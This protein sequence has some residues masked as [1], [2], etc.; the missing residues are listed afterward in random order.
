MLTNPSPRLLPRIPPVYRFAFLG[1]VVGILF[2]VTVVWQPEKVAEA[3][4]DPAEAA[5][6]VPQVDRRLLTE[7]GDATREE[8]LMLEAEPLR[9]L[10]GIAIDVGPSTA[11]ALG[12]PAVP[13][14]VDEVRANMG[15][16][17]GRW[18][19]YEGVLEDLQGPREGHPIA[20]YSI[21]EA[22]IRVAS[23][24]KVLA[25]FSIPPR[26]GIA[27]GSWVKA[28]GFLLKLRDTTYPVD[29]D[30]APM[31]VGREL[32]PDYEDW[33]P[34]TELDETL[35]ATI[36]D[37]DYFPGTK[38]W[39]TLEEDQTEPLWHLAAFVRDTKQQRSLADWRKIEPLNATSKVYE[40]LK[41]N[42]LARGT[43][44]RVFGTLVRRRVLAAP[45]NPAGVTFWT[46]AWVQVREFGG[47]LIP[48]W[49]P[50]RSELPTG[51]PLEVRGFYYR[52]QAYE[53]LKGDRFRVPLFVAADL[54]PYEL[55]ADRTMREIGIGLA[56]VLT[57][58]MGLFWLAQRRA[59]RAS[60]AHSR[61]M[62]ARRRRRRE[63]TRTSL[64]DIAQPASDTPRS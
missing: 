7:A 59:S 34:V 63:K 64:A 27:I 24:A 50:T 52:W 57:V 51:T 19:W 53:G 29:I 25:A 18:L 4:I 41:N 33:G 31:L 6:V 56:S 36:K 17:R 45:P 54:D 3:P 30:K 35:L 55:A 37:D 13:V 11:H 60:V 44:L 22:T 12:S 26:V 49:T 62:D 40:Q 43:P 15:T 9:H 23:G 8:R 46:I 48:V 20:G 16:L 2:Y 1:T 47:Q 28:E 38:A 21:Y 58:L 61:D 32:L 10:L 14:P 42:E 39:H 5:V